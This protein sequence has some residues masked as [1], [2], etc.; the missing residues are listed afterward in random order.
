MGNDANTGAFV[1]FSG[2]CDVQT[3]AEI[4]ARLGTGMTAALVPAHLQGD[5][6]VAATELITNSVRAGASSVEVTLHSDPSRLE[7]QVADNAPGVPRPA[8]PTLED[9]HGRGLLIVGALAE[10]W[11][12][13]LLDPVGKVVW[14]RF[15]ADR[16]R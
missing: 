6:A 11:G 8:Q 15:A 3:P 2:E 1:L 16:Y 13:R 5:L 12:Y 10:Q 14:A 7:I 4:R 9:D